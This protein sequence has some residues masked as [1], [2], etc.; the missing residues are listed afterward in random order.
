MKYIQLHSKKQFQ[1]VMGQYNAKWKT[2]MWD[3][4]KENTCYIPEENCFISLDKAVKFL[5]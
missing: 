2:Y 4:F 1:E 5:F 3:L